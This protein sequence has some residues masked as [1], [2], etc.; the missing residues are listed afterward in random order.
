[1]NSKNSIIK[2]LILLMTFCICKGIVPC[3]DSVQSKVCF[4][5]DKI[6]DYVSTNNPEPFP[7]LV[8]TFLSIID[9]IRVDEERQTVTLLLKMQLSW[10]DLR[11]DV[12]RSN[13]DTEKYFF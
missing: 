11:L 13:E 5:V 1:M 2:I 3:K 6:E 10:Y 8:D 7:T 12:D 9:V 4:L